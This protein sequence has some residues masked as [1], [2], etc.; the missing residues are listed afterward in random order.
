MCTVYVCIYE[1]DS[2]R[3]EKEGDEMRDMTVEFILEMR[4]V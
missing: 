3:G 4:A 1:R 2:G